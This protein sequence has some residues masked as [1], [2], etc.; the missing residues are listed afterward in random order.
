[1][2]Q[3]KASEQS[4][5]AQSQGQHRGG[6]ESFGDLRQGRSHIS[7][8]S[9]LISLSR[10]LGWALKCALGMKVELGNHSH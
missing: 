4:L 6:E 2:N 7:E 10:G 9:H 8:P 5:P 1:M 3:R